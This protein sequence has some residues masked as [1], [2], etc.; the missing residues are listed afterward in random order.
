VQQLLS[1]GSSW[2]KNQNIE[3]ND[4]EIECWTFLHL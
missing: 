4:I 3:K 2:K 1:F